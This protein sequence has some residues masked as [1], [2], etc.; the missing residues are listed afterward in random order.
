MP[1]TYPLKISVLESYYISDAIS[2][3]MPPLPP[4]DG[5]FQVYPD[6]LLKLGD[7]ILEVTQTKKDV[8]VEMSPTELRV[9]REI[10]KSSVVIGSERVGMNLMLKVYEG[11]K[12]LANSTY[13]EGYDDAEGP[14][15][16]KQEIDR[17]L[18][19][20]KKHSAEQA[21]QEENTYDEHQG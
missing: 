16:N 4:P 1:D 10:A 8:T 6:F 13:T 18:N 3:H 20:F 14:E 21:E 12:W 2:E 9:L 7:A 17:K 15:L 19:E 5:S 11:L